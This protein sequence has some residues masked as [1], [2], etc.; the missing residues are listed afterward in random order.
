VEFGRDGVGER[1]VLAEF[2]LLQFRV[3]GDD[4]VTA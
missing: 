1:G 4:R 3:G 2:A